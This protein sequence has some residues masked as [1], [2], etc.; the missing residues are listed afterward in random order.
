LEKQLKKSEQNIKAQNEDIV[1]LNDLIC[2]LNC[3][4]AFF[5]NERDYKEKEITRLK[6]QIQ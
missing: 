3:K 1:K 2:N 6:E 4:H 5:E